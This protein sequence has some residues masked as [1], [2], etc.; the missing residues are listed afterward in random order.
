MTEGSSPQLDIMRWGPVPFWAKEVKIGYSTFNARAVRRSTPSRL[1]VT[2][3][4]ARRCLV[5]VD[6]FFEWKNTRSGKQP[7]LAPYPADR[8]IAWP[9]S[10]HVGNVRNN[11]SSLIEPVAVA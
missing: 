3:N 2:P 5:P 4:S 1:S 10:A 9:V 6:N 11:D 7:L 8:M